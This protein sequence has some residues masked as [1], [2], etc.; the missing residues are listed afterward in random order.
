[1]QPGG[2]YHFENT[3]APLSGENILKMY[4]CEEGCSRCCGPK[5]FVALTNTRVIVRHQE[6]NGCLGCSKGAHIDTA[7][8][9]PDIEVVKEAQRRRK[10]LCVA[11][12]TACITC[13]L[14]CFLIGLLHCGSCCG[15][16]PKCIGVKGGFGSEIL[17]PMFF[18]E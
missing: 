17:N 12:L 11:L 9:L 14:P 18:V 10:N 6:P 15:D 5:A 4:Q 7:I 8:Y 1:M 13:T 3:F 16:L 2:T